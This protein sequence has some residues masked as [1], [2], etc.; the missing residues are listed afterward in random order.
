MNTTRTLTNPTDDELSAAVAEYVAGWTYQTFP[1]G[2]CPHIKH[3][4]NAKGEHTSIYMNG[5][6]A[7][8]ADAV[9]PLL[10]AHTKRTNEKRGGEGDTWQIYAPA[11]EN[12]VW[13]VNPVWMHHDGFIE[14]TGNGNQAKTFPRAACIALLRASGIEVKTGQ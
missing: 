7:T 1:N 14:E 2:A 12:D 3:W 9:L 13:T 10:T 5:R 4:K 8:S 11:D 6:F